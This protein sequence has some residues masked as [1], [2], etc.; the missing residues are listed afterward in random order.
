[1]QFPHLLQD[2]PPNDFIGKI[3]GGPYL[4]IAP[5]GHYE[6]CHVDADDG[7]LCILNGQKRVRM[8]PARSFAYMYPHAIGS[9]GRTV[10]SQVNIEAPDL[11][12]H[13]DFVHAE[14]WDVLLN[15][16]IGIAHRRP[17]WCH[18]KLKS[19]SSDVSHL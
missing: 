19:L 12:M 8:F 18:S 6:Y 11:A 5:K 9:L 3:H 4:W 2:L 1:M 7:Y 15:S 17:L 16:G 14:H 10:Q 13:P